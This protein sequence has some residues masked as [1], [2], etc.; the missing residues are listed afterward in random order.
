VTLDEL[1]RRQIET[2]WTLAEIEDRV[3][4]SLDRLAST[5]DSGLVGRRMERAA[6]ARAQA[7]RARALASKYAAEL[8]AAE[9]D[10]PG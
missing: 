5:G 1:R 3:A 2:Y 7:E 6:E 8:D 10:T 9:R 4:E